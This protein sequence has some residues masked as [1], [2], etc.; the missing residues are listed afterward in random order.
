MNETQII[1]LSEPVRE[2]SVSVVMVITGIPARTEQRY[3]ERALRYVYMETGHVGQNV[4]LQGV[5]L[6]IGSV[7]IGA[8]QDREVSR[9]LQLAEGE[10]PLYIMPLGKY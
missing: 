10:H 8:F 9:V 7:V 1:S 3:G 4:S 2:G 5:A 6:G